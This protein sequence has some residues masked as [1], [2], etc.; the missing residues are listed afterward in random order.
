[1]VRIFVEF[2]RVEAAIKG[3][4]HFQKLNFT[5]MPEQI[6]FINYIKPSQQFNKPQSQCKSSKLITFGRLCGSRF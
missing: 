3:L 4:H 2:Q 6:I 1:M 5:L